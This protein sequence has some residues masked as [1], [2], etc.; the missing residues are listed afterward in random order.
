MSEVKEII[1]ENYEVVSSI[2]IGGKRMILAISQDKKET[3]PYL[4]CIYT[5]NEL[6]GKYENAIASDSYPEAIKLYADDIKVE[7]IKLEL[8]QRV[9][10]EDAKGVYCADEIRSLCDSENIIGKIVVIS[11]RYLR[12]GFKN[13]VNQL[14]YITCGSGA[15]PNSRGSACFCYN[16][17]D[18]KKDRVERHQILGYLNPEEIPDFAQKSLETVKEKVR[19]EKCKDAR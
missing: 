17:Y 2:Q 7:A 12:H 19:K 13:K 6:F 4:K 9:M 18:G 8:D 15:Y 16:L 10:G 3:H 14:Y 11:D 1:N 5:E